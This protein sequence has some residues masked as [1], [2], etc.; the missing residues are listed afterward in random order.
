MK[1]RIRYIFILLLLI[2]LLPACSGNKSNKKIPVIKNG[3]ID[4]SGWDFTKDGII[5]L[6]VAKCEY[7]VRRINYNYDEEL[8][9][10]WGE[11]TNQGLLWT[12]NVTKPGKFKVI[13]EDNGNEVIEYVLASSDGSLLLNAKGN[14]GVMSKKEQEGTIMINQT[15][16][17]KI[18]IYPKTT[19][20]RNRYNFKGVELIPVE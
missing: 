2:I 1:K 20:R 13:S 9:V 3:I 5:K 14:I 11:K 7:A 4:L 12:V 15:G 18:T 19:D 6:P 17:Q 10:R 16:S 8:T